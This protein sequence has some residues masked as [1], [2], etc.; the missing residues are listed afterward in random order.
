MGGKIFRRTEK[1]IVK[2]IKRAKGIIFFLDYDGT[3][4]PIRKKPSLARIEKDTKAL[5]KKLQAEPW[6]EIF[7]ISGRSLKNVKNLIGLK[8]IHYIGNHG[9]E[10]DGQY[11]YYVTDDFPYLMFCLSGTPDPS[12]AKGGP[13]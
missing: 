10:L 6:A 5:L 13:G 3:L 1:D 9:M 8:S 4:T 7:I 2:K 12:F 11:G